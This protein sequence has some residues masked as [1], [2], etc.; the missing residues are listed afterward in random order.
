MSQ[1]GSAVGGRG[2]KKRH[3]GQIPSPSM[4]YRFSIR[5]GKGAWLC[6]WARKEEDARGGGEKIFDGK[7]SKNC[8]ALLGK[9]LPLTDRGGKGLIW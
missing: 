6:G 8:L 2:I 4:V 9:D 7:G 1:E 3:E 5:E